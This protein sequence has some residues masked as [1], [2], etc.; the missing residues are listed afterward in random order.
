MRSLKKIFI[1]MLVL[2]TSALAL[3][4]VAGPGWRCELKSTKVSGNS[5]G[6]GAAI[7]LARGTGTVRCVAADGVREVVTPVTVKL[8]GGGLGLGFAHISELFVRAVGVGLASPNDLFG[9]L[10]LQENISIMMLEHG[11]DIG[12]YEAVNNV[13]ASIGVQLTGYRGYGFEASAEVQ[14]ISIVPMM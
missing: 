7:S 12:I 10:K 14:G 2:F 11:S 3:G 4:D 6:V 13:G 9:R 8:L 5:I 1:S